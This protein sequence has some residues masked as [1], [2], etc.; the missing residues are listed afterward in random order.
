MKRKILPVI[1][2]LILI[3]IVGAALV[4]SYL[5][6]KFSY[7]T[8]RVDLAEH[9]NVSGQ[10]LAIVLQDELL[11]EIAVLKDGR[12]YFEFAQVQQLFSE[13]FYADRAEGLLLYT[14]PTDTVT[15]RFDEQQYESATG[16][17]GTDY[18][19]CYQEGEK[20]YVAADYIKLF[21]NFSYEIYDYHMQVY[22]QWGDAL[23]A[24]ALK[25]T[26]VRYQGGIK[27]PILTDVSEGEALEILERMETWC[28]VKTKDAVIGYVENKVLD[29]EYTVVETPVT[30]VAPMEY[31]ANQL[32][33]RV[34]LG[35]HSI[36]GPAGNDTLE[37]M[38]S[39][40][41][42]M[43]VVAPTWFSMTDDAGNIRSFGNRNYVDKAHGLGLYVWGV[44][45]NFNYA[46]E[47]N[48]SVDEYAVLSST[49]KRQSL[50]RN[51]V[52]QAQQLGLDG[53]NLDF[54]GLDA[55]CGTHY[56]QFLR[57]LSAECRNNGL[58]LSIDNY[59]PFDFNSFYRLDV[60]GEIADY[61]I[62]M[63]YDEHWHGSGN[64]GSV[65]SI[66]YVT[67][68]LNRTLEDVPAHK[69]VN[70]IPFYTILWKT[71]G[72]DVTDEYVTMRNQ[73]ALISRNGLQPQWDEVTCQNYAE[74]ISDGATYRIWFED[75]QSI[76]SKLN[77][78]MTKDIGGLAVWRLG[79]EDKSIW[80][81]LSTYSGMPLAQ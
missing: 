14:T 81:L 46:N 61:V 10:E 39:G 5:M 59:V 28:K 63:G 1:V 30:D 44:L 33:V 68:G 74:W 42:G 2:A 76:M 49:T 52:S 62:I 43:N 71:Q 57:E 45:D 35:W 12:C 53:I 54:E 72:A 41:K 64:P 19:I 60:Q 66:G 51:V 18:V 16:A 56:V 34:S 3:V 40:C 22:T 37:S 38:V 26:A 9:Y 73:A 31:T 11:E 55:A 32:P 8:E 24:D 47:N 36:G 23:M 29:T 4:G 79:Y 48:V 70:A 80:E 77:V 17:V 27:S 13:V 58:V 21:V 50:V 6:E 75:T 20:L 78:M 69:V 7:S 65:A 25:E 67:D 15:V